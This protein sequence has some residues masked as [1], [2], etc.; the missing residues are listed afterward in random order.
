[1]CLCEGTEKMAI[2]FGGRYILRKGG[3][4]QKGR[5]RFIKGGVETPLHTMDTKLSIFMRVTIIITRLFLVKT[6]KLKVN[7]KYFQLFV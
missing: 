7:H 5:G 6:L 1:M 4:S 2:F 3:D